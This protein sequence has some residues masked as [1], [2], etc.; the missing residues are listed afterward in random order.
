MS[1]FILRPVSTGTKFDLIASNGE[2]IAW[3]EIYETWAAC[4]NGVASV[5]KNAPVAKLED[6][7]EEPIRHLT[8]PKFEL[9]LDK[10]GGFRFRLKARNGKIIAVSDR[11][12]TKAACERGI[13]SV[14]KNAPVALVEEVWE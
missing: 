8:N 2:A 13:L 14:R 3:S 7:T 6:Q 1:K 4:R 10:T 9:Y 5:R 11:Y 12:C